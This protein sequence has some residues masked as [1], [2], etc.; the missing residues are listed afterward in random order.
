HRVPATLRRTSSRHYL[1]VSL[2]AK[3]PPRIRIEDVW[4]TLDDGRYP[5]KRTVGSKVDVW[6]TIVRDGHE[7]LA[8]AVRYRPPGGRRWREVS[9]QREPFAPDRWRGS[10]EVTDLGRWQF[11][12]VAWVDRIASWRWELQRKVEAGQEDL[13]SE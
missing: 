1:H 3:L 13:S 5:V 8:A 4:P 12:V 10:F 11:G 9:M 6:A 7:V 2:P